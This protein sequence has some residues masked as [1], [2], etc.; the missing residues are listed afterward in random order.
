MS[1][2]SEDV[3][4]PLGKTTVDA[5]VTGPA[6]AGKYPGIV[7]VAGSGPTDRNWETPFL[8]GTNGSAR[9]L[10][11]KLASCGYVTIR[12]DKR[13]TGP[14]AKENAPLMAGAS[15]EG[16]FDELEG[17]VRNLR[18]RPNVDPNRVF[19][20][21][22]SEGAIHV[23]YYQTH[24]NVTPFAGMVLTGAPGR[25]LSDIVNYQV[26]TQVKGAANGDDLVARYHEL[27]KKFEAGQPFTPDAALPLGVNQ[28]VAAL[29]APANQP[30]TREFWGFKPADYL[31]KVSQP[32]LVI[33]GKK[34]L[35]C[36]WQLDGAVLEEVAKTGKSN[37]TFR[38]PEN[39]NHVL[40]HE[41]KPRTEISL[42]MVTQTY[43]TAES[44]LDAETVADI[45]EWLGTQ[46]R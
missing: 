8:P 32:V 36:D 19:A 35:Q 17:A 20:L 46:S 39:A 21:T 4:W 42:P 14:R 25:S 9:L 44:T 15:L 27:I 18:S 37:L 23:L 24:P 33:I 10:A 6:E 29:S 43:N 31:R 40:K 5:T 13:F 41:P 22:S 2:K 26:V 30:F 11:E 7:F 16:H 34:D 28:L 3:S 45:L 38:Y 12:Y 1:T